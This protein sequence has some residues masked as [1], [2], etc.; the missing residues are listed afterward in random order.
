MPATGWRYREIEMTKT[1]AQHRALAFECQELG[2]YAEAACHYQ[3]AIDVYPAGPEGDLRVNDLKN[4]AVRVKF[5]VEMHRYAE[6]A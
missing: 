5:C 4:L 3:S 2:K 1:T 6:V